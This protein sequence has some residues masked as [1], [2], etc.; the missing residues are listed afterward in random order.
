MEQAIDAAMEPDVDASPNV[1]IFSVGGCLLFYVSVV[2][3]MF[4]IDNNNNNNN[5]INLRVICLLQT[6]STNNDNDA[7]LIKEQSK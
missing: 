4:Q 6:P 2:D 1:C 3:F 5:D 7:F